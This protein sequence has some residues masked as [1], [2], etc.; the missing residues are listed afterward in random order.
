MRLMSKFDI[1]NAL[2]GKWDDST[3]PKALYTLYIEPSPQEYLPVVIEG[4][5]SD[6]RKVQS[7]CSELA[8]LLSEEHPTLVYPH[9]D[10]FIQNLDAKAPVLRWE[11]VCVLGN[12]AQ[13]DSKQV[14]PKHLDSIIGFLDN[15]SIVLQGHA[16]RALAKIAHAYP[17][18]AQRIF[19]ELTKATVHFPGNKVGFIVEAM[20][21][22][23]DIDDIR[24]KVKE[25]VE[26]YLDHEVK[27][28]SKKAWR[29][30]KKI[31]MK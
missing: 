3:R 26:P 8:A 13:A 7:G 22:F 11:A 15:K 2:D 31:A 14:I 10:L 23:L 20:E 1:L 6:K 21:Y 30:H 18:H 24:L 9:V 25:F 5:G 29:L 17:E 28:V 4:L 12:L 16:V 27:V 19:N